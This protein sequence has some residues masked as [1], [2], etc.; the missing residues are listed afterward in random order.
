MGLGEGGKERP[1][2]SLGRGGSS[3]LKVLNKCRSMRYLIRYHITSSR[4]ARI[5]KTDNYKCWQTCRLE[6]PYVAESESVRHSVVSIS[7]WS[8]RLLPARLLCPGDSPGKNTGVGCHFLLQ[9]IFPTQGSNPGLLH[10]RQ[11]LY[12]MLLGRNVKW[13]IFF[14]KQFGSVSESYT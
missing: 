8:H 1:F 4:M 6:P 7:L 14:G 13:R 12:H 11:I 10:C 5:K 3:I 2:C 9:G